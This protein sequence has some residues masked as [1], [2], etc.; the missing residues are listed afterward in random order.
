M[1]SVAG[2]SIAVTVGLLVFGV[3]TYGFL[4]LAARGTTEAG[5]SV[6]GVFW[7][8]VY[9]LG[10]GL[11]APLEQETT[12]AVSER[13]ARGE[14]VGP[15]LARVV[16][17]GAG[18]TGAVVLLLLVLR[19]PLTRRVFGGDPA[20]VGW[21]MLAMVAF[22]GLYL[23]RGLLAGTG[24]FWIYGGQFIVEGV[25]RVGAVAAIFVTATGSTGRIAA[26]IAVAPFLTLLGTLPLLPRP[27]GRRRA[28]AWGEVTGNLGW[29][30]LASV[31][32][33]GVAN[34][35]PVVLTLLAPQDEGLAGRFLAAFVIVRIPLFFTSALQAAL[36]PHLVGSVERGDARGFTRALRQVLALVGGLG[37]VGLAALATIG[38]WIIT[39]MFG[40]GFYFG[41]VDLVALGL[42]SVLLLL[43]ALLQSAV[44][45][46]GG[47]RSVALAWVACAM[48]FAHACLLPLDPLPRLDVAYVAASGIVPL[49]LGAMLARRRRLAAAH[50]R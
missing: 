39:T 35:G 23:T 43:A 50:P 24:R 13:R 45:A 19:E 37:A 30:L 4:T 41:R 38:P 22:A 5:Y 42:S 36:L 9:G 29:L 21:L 2:G 17:L 15:V 25:L 12:R 44:L 3:T 46:T 47:H 20:L 48:V 16:A 8:L 40:A 18:L 32:W 31:V 26:V 49:I 34:A 7:S 10:G 28:S 6:I 27:G 11:F 1:P 14:A 33:Q